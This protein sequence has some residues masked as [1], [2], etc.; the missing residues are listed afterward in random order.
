M[1]DEAAVWRWC[2]GGHDPTTKRTSSAPSPT[3]VARVADEMRLDDRFVICCCPRR[4]ACNDADTLRSGDGRLRPNREE[5]RRRPP[6][7]SATR[8]AC[9]TQIGISGRNRP[10]TCAF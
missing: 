4:W 1:S 2:T 9:G 8:A 10:L 5:P 3:H 7:G 6:S